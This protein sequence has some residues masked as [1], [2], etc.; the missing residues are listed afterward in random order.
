[1]AAGVVLPDIDI[2]YAPAPFPER[3]IHLLE[4]D[5]QR[6]HRL[7]VDTSAGFD[8][9]LR[10]VAVGTAVSQSHP[11]SLGYRYHHLR[12]TVHLRERDRTQTVAELPQLAVHVYET[13]CTAVRITLQLPAEKLELTPVPVYG[14]PVV[15]HYGVVTP[16]DPVL[17][18]PVGY[19][20]ERIGHIRL[21]RDPWLQIPSVGVDGDLEHVHVTH[22][23]DLLEIRDHR[24][25]VLRDEYDR[26]HVA[27]GQIHPVDQLPVDRI[28]HQTVA[29]P[30]TVDHPLGMESRDVGTSA[31]AY[32]HVCSNSGIT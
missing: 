8:T 12:H 19:L 26:V 18:D 15:Y 25:R 16:Y 21:E 1:M 4:R 23:P 13:E 17:P 20:L 6:A 31:G 11:V 7:P 30:E 29:R 14:I 22:G 24:P 27:T 32:Y 10:Q 9:V 28:A 3:G 5:V 2:P